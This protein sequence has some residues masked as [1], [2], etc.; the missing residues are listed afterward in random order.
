MKKE[1]EWNIE[2]WDDNIMML[3]RNL[4]LILYT[5]LIIN[6]EQRYIQVNL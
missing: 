6:Y 5:I 3:I 1:E 2:E 4:A